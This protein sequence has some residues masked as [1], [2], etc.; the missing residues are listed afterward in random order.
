MVKLDPLGTI[1]VIASI[2]SLL[3]AMQWGGQTLPWKSSK[4]IGLLVGA[5]VL[6]AHFLVLQWKMG[7]DATLP[8]PILKQRSIASGAF[9]LLFFSIPIYTV[10]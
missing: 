4:V 2:C 1:L 9:Y 5:G 8:Y 3:L 7:D 10:G 6:F